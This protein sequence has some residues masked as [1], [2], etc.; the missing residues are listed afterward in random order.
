MAT[1]VLPMKRD[2]TNLSKSE[3]G[4]MANENYAHMKESLQNHILEEFPA[5]EKIQAYWMKKPGEGR[6][7]STLILFTPEGIVITGDLCPRVGTRGVISDLNYGRGWF[8]GKLSGDYLCQKFLDKSWHAE[9]ATEDLKDM[10]TCVRRGEYDDYGWTGELREA[11]EEREGALDEVRLIYK[12]LKEVKQEGNEEEIGWERDALAEA[13]KV[14]GPLREKVVSLREALATELERLA[15]RCE[16]GETDAVGFANDYHDINSDFE[17]TPGYG[18]PP[19]DAAWLC[20]IQERFSELIQ[21]T[22]PV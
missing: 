21:E 18:Y 22:A 10:A 19:A 12:V 8:S 1:G 6:M 20:A 11:R 5:G 4:I 13:K 9:L 3:G 7:M 16:W 17:S 15:Q 2:L 14:L